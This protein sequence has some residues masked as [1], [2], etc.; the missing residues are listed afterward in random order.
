MTPTQEDSLIAQFPGLVEKIYSAS[1]EPGRWSRVV[2]SIALSV[3]GMQA[4]LFTPYHHPA[5]GGFLY[6]WR[7][8]EKDLIRYATQYIDHDVWAQAA[9]RLGVRDCNVQTD[10]DLLPHNTLLDSVYYND[11]ISS[12]GVA[13]LCSVVIFA[14]GPGL[15]GTVLSVYRGQNDE[16]FDHR[17]RQLMKL[18]MPHLSRAFGLMHRLGLARHQEQALRTALDSLSVGVFLLNELGAVIFTN[19]AGHSMVARNDGLHFNAKQRLSAAGSQSSSGQRLEDWLSSIFAKSKAEQGSFNDTFQ[20]TPSNRASRY[21]VQCCSLGQG[22]PLVSAEGASH[23]VFVTDPERL[24]L[25]N[26]IQLQQVLGLTPAEARVA[27][28]LV[29]GGT[30]RDVANALSI[31][32]ET[33]RSPCKSIYAKIHNNDQASLTR[34]VLSL[35]RAIA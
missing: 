33:V 34:V 19:A 23:V 14:G 26:L 10:E 18:L 21:S 12:M 22:D 29:Q 15:P 27:S 31:S 1:A 35:G 8:E 25:P 13:R 16:P 17:D 11:F 3:G 9:Q 28:T 4:M 2:E 7:V 20:V 32:E 6:P 30:N 5:V 24:E